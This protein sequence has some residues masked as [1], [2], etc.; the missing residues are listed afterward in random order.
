[1]S[2][3]GFYRL[4]EI[5]I[6]FPICRSAWF[7]GVREGRYP[8]PCKHGKSSLWRKVDIHNLVR[9]IEEKGGLHDTTPE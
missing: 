3:I 7:A 4:R 6:I 9:E 1:M 8:R 2:E 5:L